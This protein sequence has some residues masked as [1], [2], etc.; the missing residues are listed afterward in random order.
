MLVLSL[1]T[2]V[3]K[4]K[5]VERF[6][7]T[8]AYR[9]DPPSPR[10]MKY[11]DTYLPLNKSRNPLYSCL[12]RQLVTSGIERRLAYGPE[13]VAGSKTLLELPIDADGPG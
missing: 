11:E 6:R 12:G 7:L 13:R 8:L 3:A 5:L 9:E 1:L 4:A 10:I 2:R